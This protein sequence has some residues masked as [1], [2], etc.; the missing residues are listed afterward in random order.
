MNEEA[1]FRTPGKRKK[2]PPPEEPEILEVDATEV[3]PRSGRGRNYYRC[4][5]L[6]MFGDPNEFKEHIRE[7]ERRGDRVKIECR[8]CRWTDTV[9][10]GV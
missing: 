10:R 4:S 1:T 8:P 7:H 3:A 9:G 6:C 2:P 5:C